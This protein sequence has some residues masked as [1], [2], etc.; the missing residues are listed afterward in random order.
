MDTHYTG[1]KITELRKAKGW[2]QK[3]IAEKLHV[4]V[5]AV[6]KWERG[7]NY[8]DLSLMESLAEILEITVSELLGLKNEPAEQ[9]IKN[10][11]EIS[12]YEKNESEQ[13]FLK[14]I[15]AI[16]ITTIIFIAAS[17]FVYLSVSNNDIMKKLF[18]ISGGTGTLNILAVLLGLTAW[19]LAVT[20]IF[21]RRKEYR[22][23]YYSIF[24]FISCS[25]SLH[26]P[27]LVTYLMMR[28]EYTATVEDVIGAY[29]FGS[30][31]LLLGTILFNICAVIIHREKTEKQKI[32]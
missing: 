31:V 28:F 18:E 13:C 6:S 29:Y 12:V 1:N 9:I 8:P 24:S 5:A 7:L 27:S 26:I 15:R 2:T 4:S 3:D 22:W 16:T 25:V 20:S 32:T 10:I 30:A 23:K 11:T 17:Y 21:S 19:G 14:K